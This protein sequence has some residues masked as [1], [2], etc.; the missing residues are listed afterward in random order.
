MKKLFFTFTLFFCV[1]FAYADQLAWLNFEQAE[2]AVNFLK[3]EKKLILYCACCDVYGPTTLVKIKE[4][5]H[6]HP[7]IGDKVYEEYYEVVVKG[8]T[9]SGEEIEYG[10]DLAYVYV[11]VGKLAKCLGLELGFE[12][13]PCTEPFSWKK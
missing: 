12:C 9:A 13:D 11:K 10:V 4:V 8:V 5:Y 2:K 7:S 3:S 6:R 1:S